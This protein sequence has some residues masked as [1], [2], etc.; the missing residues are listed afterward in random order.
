MHTKK[1]TFQKVI[2]VMMYQIGYRMCILYEATAY[3]YLISLSTQAQTVKKIIG[4]PNDILTGTEYSRD[5][6]LEIFLQQINNLKPSLI[7]FHKFMKRVLAESRLS[8]ILGL[9]HLWVVGSELTCGDQKWIWWDPHSNTQLNSQA[10][11]HI[12]YKLHHTL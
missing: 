10:T 9:S 7:K 11:P 1:D 2:V 12:G 8:R 6:V 3:K 4:N 5:T